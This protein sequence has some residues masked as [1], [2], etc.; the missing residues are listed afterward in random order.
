MTPATAYTPLPQA[1]HP[2]AGSAHSHT[3]AA[4][5]TRRYAALVTP[6]LMAVAGW[7]TLLLPLPAQAATETRSVP[8][9]QAITL[10]AGVE[11]TVR[12]GPQQALTLTADDAVLPLLESVVENGSQ[13]PTLVLRYLRG[14]PIYTAQK[15]RATVVMPKLSAVRVDGSGDVKIEAFNTPALKLSV[16]GSGDIVMQGLTAEDLQVGIAG[17]GDVRGSGA[18]RRLKVS[19]AGSGDVR[20]MDLRAEAVA[21]H[22]A[23]SG[24]V[25][26]QAQGTLDISIVGS[27]DVQYTGAARLKQTVTG[28][29]SIRPR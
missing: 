12:Q 27:G 16:A 22:I 1:A 18:T 6:L 11:L 5:I 3:A 2:T 8:D 10:S 13:G 25:A 17:S 7:L 19:V 26:V 15:V 29:G 14:S 9:F 21:V 24:D 28:S 4:G 23:G 20:L